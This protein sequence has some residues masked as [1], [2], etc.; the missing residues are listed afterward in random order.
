MPATSVDDDSPFGRYSTSTCIGS[1]LTSDSEPFLPASISME[2]GSSVVRDGTVKD[3]G[4]EVNFAPSQESSAMDS[5]G[6]AA[7]VEPPITFEVGA[8]LDE[9]G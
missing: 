9:A 4:G 2:G 5:A 3:A 1:A 6:V 8:S 7:V